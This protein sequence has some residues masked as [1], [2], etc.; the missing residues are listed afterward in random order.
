[1]SVITRPWPCRRDE[2]TLGEILQRWPPP[3]ARGV[4]PYP[5]GYIPP[6]GVSVSWISER[7][8]ARGR[9]PPGVIPPKTRSVP[10]PRP[11]PSGIPIPFSLIDQPPFFCSFV[12]RLPAP[13]FF[14][15]YRYAQ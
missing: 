14:K 15:A 9:Y 4:P 3:P 2:A 8:W 10:P 1:M 5:G 7:D 11:F 13:L 6:K 12:Y